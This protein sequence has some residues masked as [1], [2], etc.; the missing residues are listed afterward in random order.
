VRLP[1]ALPGPVGTGQVACPSNAMF[2]APAS[3]PY[4]AMFYGTSA[5]SPALYGEGSWMGEGCGKCN[6]LTGTSNVDS[7]QSF[8]TTIVLKASNLCPGDANPEWCGDGKVHF[9][10]AAP[11]FD[12]LD[13]SAANGCSAF[14]PNETAFEVCENWPQDKGCE[15]GMFQNEVL[16]R[17]CSNFKSLG[18]DN[19]QVQCEEV[20]CPPELA[21]LS[22]WNQN[23]GMW[24]T[25]ADMPRFCAT[26][27]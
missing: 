4:G 23:G 3:N 6:M 9:D 20:A 24:P 25:E 2:D 22:C 17:E 7:V 1:G 18:W 16:Q 12:R 21:D 8:S 5:V 10:I 15:C 27:M 14:E 19:P 11:G 26:N 13:A